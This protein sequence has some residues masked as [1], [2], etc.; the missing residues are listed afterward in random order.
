MVCD[1]AADHNLNNMA[2]RLESLLCI[3]PGHHATMP[4]QLGA[5]ISI[6]LLKLTL[7]LGSSCAF[8]A[9]YRLLWFS[10]V[11]GKSNRSTS[12]AVLVAGGGGGAGAVTAAGGGGGGA[13]VA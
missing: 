1:L 12:G 8:G 13:D 4:L 11:L 9:T 10:M 6:I 7:K 2:A 5:Y 3:G